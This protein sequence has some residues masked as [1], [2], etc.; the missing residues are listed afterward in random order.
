MKGT[1]GLLVEAHPRGLLGDLRSVLLDLK[2]AAY[3]F[4][5]TVIEAACL[6]AER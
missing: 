5:D 6:A 4:S 3:Y 1:A 2:R